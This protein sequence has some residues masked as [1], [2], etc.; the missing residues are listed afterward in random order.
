MRDT[1]QYATD[2]STASLCDGAN[3]TAD[4]DALIARYIASDPLNRGPAD[5]RVVD[6]GGPVWNLI[7]HHRGTGGDLGQ[8]AAAYGLEPEAVEAA[9]RYYCRHRALIDAR[10]LLNESFFD[11]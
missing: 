5:A 8:T 9:I 3:G 1:I 11:S 4:D 2:E 10:I 6:H 7:A